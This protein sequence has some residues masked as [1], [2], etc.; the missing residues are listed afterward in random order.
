MPSQKFRR[1]EPWTVAELEQLGK[2]PDSVLARRYRRTIEEVVAE[3]ER[4]R[5]AM[6]TGPRL[7]T[8]REI[9]LLG[10][11]NDREVS[12]R[13]R[14]SYEDVRRQRL[15]LKIPALRPL[16]HKK[17]TRREEKLLGTM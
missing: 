13:L 16:R 3:R 6:Q 5:I 7:W 15:S 4:R 8:A 1:G 10:R 11:L 14:R 2:L 9:R 12:R 17:W